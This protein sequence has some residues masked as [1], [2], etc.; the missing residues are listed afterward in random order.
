MI[1]RVQLERK[2][3][4][5]MTRGRT[6][7]K[8]FFI[9]FLIAFLFSSLQ[10][11]QAFAGDISEKK[12]CFAIGTG[13]IVKGNL[14]QGKKSA[15]RMAL[16]KGVENYLVRLLGNQAVATHF[17]SLANEIL[18][19]IDQEI[20]NFHI[21]AEQQVGNRYHVFVK[22]KVNENS[23]AE[24]L[25]EAG[26]FQTV[27]R[28]V[29]VLFMVSETRGPVEVFWWQD[30]AAHPSLTPIELALHSVFQD[31]GFNPVNRIMDLPPSDVLSGQFPANLLPEDATEWGRFF[32]ADVV[33]YGESLILEDILLLNLKAIDV[34]K[35]IQ[36][37]EKSGSQEIPRGTVDS[38]KILDIMRKCVNRLAVDLCPC[39]L[40][41]INTEPEADNQLDV[42]LAGISQPR[43]FQTFSEFLKAHV[44][45]VKTIIP[46]R[47][48][49]GSMSA[50]IDFQ[51]DRITFI[52]LVLNHQNLPFPLHLGQTDTD[53]ILFYLE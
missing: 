20:E 17:E 24:K 15:I 29:K 8:H 37:C 53:N 40:R 12:D 7:R 28:S 19:T 50:T 16:L 1:S 27:N 23:V 9:I 18:P 10:F 47:I 36:I 6:Q 25:R 30:A 35:G 33:V 45:G 41:N 44:P 13:T 38:E 4:F 3:Y 49:D 31:R 32:S 51:G 5:H 14:V 26:V 46:S 39:I 48:S 34:R 11:S 2:K 22:M 42:T 43:Q 21:L 52:S